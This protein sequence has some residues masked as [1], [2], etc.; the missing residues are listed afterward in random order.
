MSMVW[1][2]KVRKEWYFPFLKGPVFFKPAY[3]AGVF[4]KGCE[5]ISEK[6]KGS[7]NNP[8]NIKG[9]ENFPF[10]EELRVWNIKGCKISFGT[11]K[12]YEKRLRGAKISMENLRGGKISIENLRGMK[13]FYNFPKNTPTGYPDLKKTGP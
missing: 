5:I 8:E 4:F 7:E 6:F 12:G 11:N 3:P 10:W 1:C 13:M 9:S 2:N